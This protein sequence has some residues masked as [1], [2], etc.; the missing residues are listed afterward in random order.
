MAKIDVIFQSSQ[1]QEMRALDIYQHEILSLYEKLINE[2]NIAKYLQAA[3]SQGYM[4]GIE[5]K[6]D[7]YR[8]YAFDD[9]VLKRIAGWDQGMV[10][11]NT[12]FNGAVIFWCKKLLRD[13]HNNDFK[14]QKATKKTWLPGEPVYTNLTHKQ[15]GLITKILKMHYRH[16]KFVEPLFGV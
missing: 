10:S 15:R 7:K 16:K 5:F 14:C 2:E 9:E 12:I 3:G 1:A 11:M 8:A 6:N 13:W 4:L